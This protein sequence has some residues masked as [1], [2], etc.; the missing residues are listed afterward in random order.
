MHKTLAKKAPVKTAEKTSE[1]I[2]LV[3]TS[4]G[5]F[6]YYSDEKRRFWEVNG[7]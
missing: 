3:S 1:I 4:K 2:L 6:I 5:G 7:P